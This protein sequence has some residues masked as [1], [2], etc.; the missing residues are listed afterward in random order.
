MISSN[1]I[2]KFA[3]LSACLSH[4]NQIRNTMPRTWNIAPVHFHYVLYTILSVL[5]VLQLVYYVPMCK[6]YLKEN[7]EVAE[8][9]AST[10]VSSTDFWVSQKAYLTRNAIIKLRGNVNHI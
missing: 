8:V 9:K 6:R 7:H 5:A 3:L 1:V 2:C 4:L 10:G